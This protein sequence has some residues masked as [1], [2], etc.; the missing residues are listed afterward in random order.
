VARLLLLPP[1]QPAGRAQREQRTV[2]TTTTLEFTPQLRP[3]L[4]VGLISGTLNLRISTRR[5]C[6]R[7]KAR[8]CSNARSR[9]YRA[10]SMAAKTRGGAHR[11]VPQGQSA[12]VDPADLAYDS[13][14]PSDTTLFRDIQPI[15]SIRCMATRQREGSTPSHRQAVRDGAEWHQLCPARRLC[16]AKRQPGASVDPICARAHGAKGHWQLGSV[17]V[18]GFASDTSATQSVVEFRANAPPARSSSTCAA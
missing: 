4:G 13:D 1:A 17:T 12:G 15:S 5:R 16:H 6:N 8:M 11:P 10:A 3:M 7:R 14:K 9:A 2:K 18:D